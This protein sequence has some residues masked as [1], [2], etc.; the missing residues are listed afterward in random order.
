MSNKTPPKQL[1]E[2]WLDT[3]FDL[4]EHERAPFIRSDA[5]P[6]E[7]R[8]AL[9]AVL[10]A[11]MAASPLDQTPTGL[12]EAAGALSEPAQANAV[13]TVSSGQRIGHYRLLRMIGEGGMASV[14]LAERD[15]GA[16]S[17]Q[18][19]LKCLKTGLA[20]SESR[21]RFLREQQIL[22]Q[23]QHPN[24]AR[25]Y[26]AGISDDGVP[27]IVMEW[28]DGQALTRYCD[29]QRLNL[30]QRLRQFQKICAAVAYAHQN[31]IV[32]RD[33]KPGNI[34][35]GRDGEP[36]LLDF[37]IAKLLDNHAEPMTRTGLNLLT[38]E[39]AAPEQFSGAAITTA[40]DVYA[41]GVVLFELLCGM[42]P[43]LFGHSASEHT[44]S[45]LVP[46]AALRKAAK[47]V[48]TSSAHD[49]SGIAQARATTVER[50][51][52][53]L[54]GDLDTIVLNALQEVPQ[55]RY[56]TATA[57]SEDIERY[58]Q[59]QPIRARK[60]TWVYRVRKFL[61]RHALAVA[62]G[63][64]M[65]SVLFTATGISVY[66]A[67]RAEIEARRAESEAK[68]AQ[69]E[70]LRAQTEAKRAS[71]VEGFLTNLFEVS[72]SGLPRDK[73]PS[74]E[75]LLEDG[76]KRV[77]DEFQDAPEVRL[78]LL[79]LLGRVQA[80][81]GF[82]DSSETLLTDAVAIA[83]KTLSPA[84]ETWL[85]ARTAQAVLLVRRSRLEQ[86]E[87]DLSASIAEHRAAGAPDSKT[88]ANALG[89]LGDV[90]RQRNRFDQAVTLIEEA[91]AM[92]KRIFGERH[93][94][95]Q[96]A[97][98]SLGVALQD[99]RRLEEAETT[100]RANLVLSKELYGDHQAQ[101]ATGLNSLAG[102]LGEIGKIQESE[103]LARQ[104]VAID[105]SVYNRPNI[106]FVSSLS[107]L[108][109][110]LLNQNK[111][112]EAKSVFERAL[113]MQTELDGN[114]NATISDLLYSL[115]DVALGLHDYQ[116]AERLKRQSLDLTRKHYG[117]RNSRVAATLGTLG[118]VLTTERR[119][120][121]AIAVFEEALA[122]QREVY[123]EETLPVSYTL[124][125]L[126]L[127]EVKAGRARNALDHIDLALRILKPL[128]NVSDV[129]LYAMALKAAALNRLS[130]YAEAKT[131]LDP[132]IQPMRALQPGPNAATVLSEGLSELG[133]AHAGLLETEEA[134]ANWN[135]ALTVMRADPAASPDDIKDL[136]ALI[137][138]ARTSAIQAKKPRSDTR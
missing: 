46:S 128:E 24:I 97:M 6:E 77:H 59:Q 133:R 72:D 68:R 67:Y 109:R 100:L 111:F 112:V 74:T 40:T 118:E 94:S 37:G 73:V 78:R 105:E 69:V 62:L 89:V 124:G 70:T 96:K 95:V 48:N 121:D 116:E 20:S 18:V 101:Y 129:T 106:A 120:D 13:S 87:H 71:A 98:E 90:Y 122:I 7:L 1:I 83:D 19:A 79:L 119:Y 50:L 113:K 57:L 30:K 27:F 130:R 8:A 64:L 31:L 5:V 134:L 126:T 38:P 108:G 125:L 132:L 11:S 54:N 10:K 138:K 49:L 32:H 2:Q 137:Q 88:L 65:V 102:V 35:V 92:S 9:L 4:E 16:F 47:T 29:E 103:Q 75:T 23:L 84:T 55:R 22:A 39:Y 26:D 114:D 45:R 136:Q 44:V 53:A 25:L 43:R 131:L 85:E 115:G 104:A 107:I 61:D 117:P 14:W 135:D 127:A 15:D 52:R 41:L 123:G 82:Y 81:L 86:S 58:L 110:Q 33:L 42:R 21:A 28:V 51:Q 36:K 3:I 63:V 12:A 17:H 91:L 80:N 60:D 66:Q 56:A 93:A 76:A 34:L 99:A